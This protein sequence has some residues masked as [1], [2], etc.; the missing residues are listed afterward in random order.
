M[1]E[2]RLGVY[3]EIKEIGEH[4]PDLPVLPVLNT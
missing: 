4:L 1:A 3:R 2:L